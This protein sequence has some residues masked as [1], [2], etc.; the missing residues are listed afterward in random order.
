[1]LRIEF[2]TNNQVVT[3]RIEGH[4]VGSFA[5]HVHSLVSRCSAPQQIVFDL[6]EVTFKW[7]R[8]KRFSGG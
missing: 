4:F 3:W 8:G 6:S 5:E 2:H 7:Y 1:M